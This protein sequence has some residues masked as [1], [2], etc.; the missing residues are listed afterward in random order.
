MHLG[1]LW[2]NACGTD[3]LESS[4]PV[5]FVWCH[6]CTVAQKTV[7]T[8][9]PF[10]HGHL[11]RHAS[12]RFLKQLLRAISG[13]LVLLWDNH[14]IHSRKLVEEFI[15]QEP[16]LH[17]EW[18]PT[19]APELNPAEFI[20]T[21]LKEHTANTAPLDIPE[22]RSNVLTGVAKIRKSQSHLQYCL[23]ASELS[24]K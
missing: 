23:S 1:S 20:W 12:D 6:S 22:L 24:W 3:K 18:F 14:P 13:E 5:E 15:K 9:H 11:E 8:R 19:C 4:S 10:V 21:Q 16:R 7:A 2:T 17:L